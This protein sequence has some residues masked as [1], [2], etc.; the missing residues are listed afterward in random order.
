MRHPD[1]EDQ[2][3]AEAIQYFR[4]QFPTVP[5]IVLS[6]YPDVELAVYLLKQG[7]LDYLVKPVGKDQL[8]AVIKQ[9]VA[10]QVI[11]KD[12]FAT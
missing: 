7:V 12:Q 11:M 4:T 1:A 5:V 10:H 2:R 3:H 6:G 9:P 8:L